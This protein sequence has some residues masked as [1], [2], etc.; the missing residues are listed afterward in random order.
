MCLK[1]R[2][3]YGIQVG[4]KKGQSPLETIGQPVKRKVFLTGQVTLEIAFALVCVFLLLL[5]SAKVFVW[6]NERLVLRQ[7]DYEGS[8]DYGRVK[9]GSS[10]EEVPLRESSSPYP[11][12][13]IFG[14]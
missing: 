1:K 9:A 6:V 10:S 4:K 14:N 13:D 12:L 2:Q 3:K 5:G 7:E 8:L 11:K